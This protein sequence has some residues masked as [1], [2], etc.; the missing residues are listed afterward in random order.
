ML[1]SIF[2][3][4]IFLGSIISGKLSDQY[5]RKLMIMIGTALQ[6][7]FSVFFILANS[8]PSMTFIRFGYGFSFGFTIALTTSLYAESSP[9]K[10]RGKGLLMLNFCISFGKVFA[11]VLA[12]IFLDSYTSGNW[13]LMMLFSSIPNILVLIGS[14]KYM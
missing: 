14:Y 8:V 13:K 12:Q 1:A 10:Y 6:F 7:I 9:M 11:I 2:Y 4:G 3:L 5:G